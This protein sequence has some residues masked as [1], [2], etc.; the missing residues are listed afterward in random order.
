MHTVL[1]WWRRNRRKLER[2]REQ[3][4]EYMHSSVQGVWWA[5]ELF[6]WTP[7]E[8]IIEGAS[9]E[10]LVVGRPHLESTIVTY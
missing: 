2:P 3:P 9:K 4:S 7:R 10:E 8:T 1:R 6:G 5:L